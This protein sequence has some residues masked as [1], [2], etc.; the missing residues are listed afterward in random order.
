MSRHH[1]VSPR[2][3]ISCR[4]CTRTAPAT[5]SHFV[6]IGPR[7]GRD[8]PRRLQPSGLTVT[9]MASMRAQLTGTTR[10]LAQRLRW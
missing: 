2:A 6:R 1:R 3:A 5:R 8:V 7:L 10:P 9:S 4:R